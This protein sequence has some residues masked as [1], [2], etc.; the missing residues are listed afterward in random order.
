MN[1]TSFRKGKRDWKP[2]NR[3]FLSHLTENLLILPPDQLVNISVSEMKVLFNSKFLKH[4]VDSSAEGSYRIKDFK[5][6]YREVERNG[7]QFISLVHTKEYIEKI[8]EACTKNE[9][10][11]EVHLTKESYEAAC[12]AVGLTISAS[13]QGD[14]AAVRPPGHHAW[15]DKT[16]GFCFFNNIAIATQKL[17]NEGKRVFI[18]DFDSHHG[19]GTQAIF[20]DTD[21][22]FYCSIHQIYT[23]PFTGFPNE[24]GSGKGTGYNLNIPLTPG[25]GDETFLRAV[26]L[27]IKKADE[28]SPDVI[29]MS[30]GFD[31]Y[32]KDRLLSLQLTQQSYYECGYRFRKYFANIFAVL[33]GGYHDDIQPCVDRF[34][35]GVNRAAR[36]SR[37]KWN[38][39][40]SIG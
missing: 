28:F 17:V 38:P 37:I 9:Y 13:E 29:A 15:R 39:D 20:Y 8:R 30:A 18:F 34:V 3:I 22:V 12:I 1:S 14:F 33:E 21:K 24:I 11:A 27:A 23:F 31:G 5:G 32:Y 26:D 16:A 25:S 6:K 19:D 7:E 2:A 35:S 36:P 10:L 40:M 4:N